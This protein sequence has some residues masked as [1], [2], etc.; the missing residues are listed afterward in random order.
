VVRWIL[1]EWKDVCKDAQNMAPK[2]PKNKK[3]ISFTI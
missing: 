2:D 3:V 1:P